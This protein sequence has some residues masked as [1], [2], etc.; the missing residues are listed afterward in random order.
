V[1]QLTVY[2]DETTR[3]KIEQAARAA[4]SSVS[5][6]VKNKLTQAIECDWPADYFSVFGSLSADDLESPESLTF[7]GDHPRESL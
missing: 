1:A 7:E 6:W 2:I 5:Q 3:K 4:K